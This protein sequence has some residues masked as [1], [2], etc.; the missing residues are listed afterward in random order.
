VFWDTMLKALD[1]DELLFILGHEMGHYVL[2]HILKLIAG[3][4]GLIL[5]AYYAAY[6]LAGRIIARFRKPF[7]FNALSDFAALPL[8]A[9]LIQIL[10]LAGTP[11]L[12]AFSRHQEHEADRF[13]LE[14]THSNHAAATAFVKLQQSNLSN[15]RPG[16]IY[17]L[18]LG[19]HPSLAERIE[20]CNRYRPWETG[21]PARYDEYIKSP[22]HGRATGQAH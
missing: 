11:V 20:F 4:S 19:S 7:G 3:C 10:V 9:L 1:E 13:G 8:G 17:K 6:L 12:M 15:P 14:L 21:Q 16:T 5:L 18:W 2:G 22:T